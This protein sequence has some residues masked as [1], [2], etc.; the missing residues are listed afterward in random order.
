M[1]TPHTRG[2]P[3]RW[4]LR[5][6]RIPVDPAHAGIT[7]TGEPRGPVCN[8]RPRTRGDYPVQLHGVLDLLTS[9]PHTRG[10]PGARRGGLG[11]EQVDPAHAGITP[12][13]RTSCRPGRSRPRTR[14]DYP[15]VGYHSHHGFTSTP[16]TRGL[17]LKTGVICPDHG[18]DPAHAG[19]T[20]GAVIPD[21]QSSR[22][23]R[24]RG[25]YPETLHVD[26][27]DLVST[28]HTRG[29]PAHPRCCGPGHLVDPAHAGITPPLARSPAD[30][31]T[32]G[33][34]PSELC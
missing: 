4:R 31:S 10:L 29:L 3:H 17:P 16:H 25:D 34:R 23:P 27:G 12:L 30:R 18:V 21:P 14:G 15:Y 19:I 8:G 13:P 6:R 26:G 7:R 33:R 11:R 1:S 9:T 24:T 28:P 22:R 20:P 5:H 2:L 32:S